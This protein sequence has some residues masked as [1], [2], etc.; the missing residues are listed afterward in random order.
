[1]RWI[2]CTHENCS[3]YN[4]RTAENYIPRKFALTIRLGGIA[5]AKVDKSRLA[6]YADLALAHS[7]EF[8]G[9]ESDFSGVNPDVCAALK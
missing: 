1:M 7:N 4:F 9:K 5:L 2:H 3:L 8:D 6:R